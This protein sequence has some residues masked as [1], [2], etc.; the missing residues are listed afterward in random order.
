MN[1][2]RESRRPIRHLLLAAG[3]GLA[4]LGAMPWAAS[5]AE[6][7]TATPTP[8]SAPTPTPEPTPSP[9]PTPAPTDTP[10]PDPTPTPAPDPTP[11]P[12]PTAAPTP[13]ITKVNL[14]RWSAMARQYTNYWCV[15][16]ATQS[17][18]NL[19]RG[20]SN[21]SYLTQK[22]YYKRIRSHNR[23]VYRTLGNDPQ[24]W[25]WGVRTY[26]GAPYVARAYTNKQQA[27]AAIVASIAK[28]ND[29]VGVTVHGGTHAWVVLGYRTSHDPIEPTKK[30]ILGFYV[31]GP[32]GTS[33]DRWPYAYLTTAQFN[34]HFTRYHEWQRKVIWEG[35]WVVIAQ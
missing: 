9:S 31:S 1:A 5:A 14:Y 22:F 11:T 17:M 28:T 3:L 16:A 21:R 6:E 20:T 4:L 30:T 19:V 15:P 26:S 18:A 24:G 2:R 29:P 27:L 8:T 13:V 10:A 35:K 12:P 33:A 25:A 23:Y 34:Q 32:L 7:P